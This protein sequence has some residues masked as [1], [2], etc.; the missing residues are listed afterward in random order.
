MQPTCVLK[1]RGADSTL[2]SPITSQRFP[3][4]FKKKLQAAVSERCNLIQNFI[5]YNF[6][7]IQKWQRKN[8]KERNPTSTL[9]QLATL[10]MV[11]PL[12]RLRL[13]R[14]F[15][16][17]NDKIEFMA[18]DQIDNAPEERARGI[19]INTRHV[20]YETDSSSLRTR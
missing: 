1:H 10:T 19:T 3:R 4:A 16:S 9:V 2:W 8:S 20:E 13:P 11:R 6:W 17:M 5:I 7:R 18:Y 14:R 15:L 12:L